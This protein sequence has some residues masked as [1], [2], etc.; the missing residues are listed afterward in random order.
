MSQEW[1]NI[2]SFVTDHELIGA[3]NDLSIHLK[4]Q[5]AG[6]RD[7]EREK[8]AKAARDSL[9]EFLTRLTTIEKGDRS[10]PVLGV[11]SRFQSLTDAIASARNDSGSYQSP[12]IREGAASALCLLDAAD[13]KGRQ[14]LL[15][16]LAELRRIVEQHQQTDTSVIFEEA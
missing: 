12:L 13:G 5:D 9:R 1:L 16:S 11:D 4:F 10:N 3:I 7:A 8:R 14:D 6:V 15:Q 2:Q